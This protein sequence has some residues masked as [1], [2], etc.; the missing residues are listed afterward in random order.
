MGGTIPWT[1]VLDWIERRKWVIHRVHGSLLWLQEQCDSLGHISDGTLVSPWHARLCAFQNKEEE[2]ILLPFSSFWQL[3]CNS[4]KESNSCKIHQAFVKMPSQDPV[5]RT[6]HLDG[7]SRSGE[8]CLHHGPTHVFEGDV[9][10]LSISLPPSFLL[11]FPLLPS[12]KDAALPH[13]LLELSCVLYHLRPKAI[14]TMEQHMWE[15]QPKLSPP[16]VSCFP[17]SFGNS[18]E[19]SIIYCDG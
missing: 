11:P 16:A 1:G 15:S 13:S 19:L 14:E 7:S 8:C 5:L 9:V 2:Q 10:F 4:N 3:F 17:S 6:S 18:S 12:V